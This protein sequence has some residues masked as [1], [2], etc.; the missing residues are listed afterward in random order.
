MKT[1]FT[2]KLKRQALLG[3]LIALMFSST[4]VKAQSEI[5]K[6]KDMRYESGGSF[7]GFR[8]SD[9]IA[10]KRTKNAKHFKNANGSFTVVTGGTYHYKDANNQ[11]QDISLSLVP[12]SRDAY[13]FANEANEFKTYLPQKAGEQPVQMI[14]SNGVA[15]KWWQQ[16]SMRF[17]NGSTVMAAQ[18]KAAALQG[19]H[20]VNYA[21]VYEGITEQFELLYNGVENN[22]IVHS[23][24]Q[25]I[26][27][28]PGGTMIELSQ[29][30]PM[31]SGWS[32]DVAGKKKQTNFS[33]KDFHIS[34]PGTEGIYFGKIVVFD[35]TLDKNTALYL[36][37]AP[38]A[39]LSE[40][41]K[42][43]KEQHVLMCNYEVRFVQGGLNVIA[44]IPADWLKAGNRSFPVTIDPTVT[45][46]PPS[47]IGDYYAPTSNWYGYQRHAN[48]YL[49]SEIGV[50]NVSISAIEY[51]RV[52]TNGTDAVSPNKVFFR[53]TPA[54]TLTAANW[55]STTYTGGL[56]ASFDASVNFHGSTSGWK[57]FTLTTPFIYNSDNLIVMVYDAYGSSGS[58]KYM[59]RSSSVSNRQAY[60]RQD[61]SDPGD[62]TGLSVES[63]LPQILITYNPTTACTGTQCWYG[64]LICSRF[65]LS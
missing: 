58:A 42:K 28:L 59:N 11:W 30:I 39:K 26:Q 43:Q 20:T 21:H 16:P 60:M 41:E 56:T 6:V 19:D 35:H 2:P 36:I 55:N 65:C 47:S 34:I 15:F 44:K 33:G 48:L 53:T 7:S 17:S 31:P 52:N 14:L 37:G 5:A 54:T 45:I 9:E 4:S 61:Y 25:Q 63:Y 3:S 10:E 46:T 50:S 8:P 22:T 29:F 62:G 38:L 1:F 57:M 40:Q 32:V 13:A 49:A 27:G 51:N 12:A 24:S 23:L 18:K 64:R